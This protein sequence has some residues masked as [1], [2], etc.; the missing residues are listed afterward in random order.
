[1]KVVDIADEAYRELGSPTDLSI[2]AIAFWLR[3]NL[4]SLNNHINTSFAVNTTTYEVEQETTDAEGTS[5]TLEIAEEEKSI[6]KKLYMLHYYDSKIRSNIVSISTDSVISVTDD[7]S[8]VTKI[9]KNEVSRVLAGIKRQEFE[10][11]KNLINQYN[12][13]KS[14]P[15][16]VAGDDTVEGFYAVSRKFNRI[17]NNLT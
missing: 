13:N 17:P 11:L 14:A 15:L 4:G 2:P 8:S 5:V 7:G 9:N 16:Q 3:T 10:E 1:M 6:L 12:L